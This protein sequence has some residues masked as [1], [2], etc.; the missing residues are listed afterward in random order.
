MK[1]TVSLRKPPPR[2]LN[3]RG[4]VPSAGGVP[5]QIRTEAAEPKQQPSIADFTGI[6]VESPK[7]LKARPEDPQAAAN[8]ALREIM[9]DLEQFETRR[10]KKAS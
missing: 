2:Q 7:R 10:S 3:M 5:T 1:D 4:F 9:T 6:K 8:E